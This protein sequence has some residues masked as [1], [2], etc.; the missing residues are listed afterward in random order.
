MDGYGPKDIANFYETGLFL[1]SLPNKTLCLRS[2]MLRWEIQKASNHMF[3]RIYD[4]GNG[5]T[6]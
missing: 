2:E 1:Q 5:T 6:P 4:W 3:V